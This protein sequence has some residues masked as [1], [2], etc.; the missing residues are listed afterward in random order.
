MLYKYIF[1]MDTAN[2]SQQ[3]H[4]RT[5]QVPLVNLQTSD[6][7]E[8]DVL[9]G[10]AA[11]VINNSGNRRFRA[12]TRYFR[13]IYATS[14]KPHDKNKISCAIVDAVRTANP[15]GR[16][17]KKHATKDIWYDIGD[18]KAREK[19]SQTIRDIY[20]KD[21]QKKQKIT[22][23]QRTASQN[24]DASASCSTDYVDD[25]SDS[26]KVVG[27]TVDPMN[28][29]NNDV[30]DNDTL[31][32]NADQV[33]K[34]KDVNKELMNYAC[35]EA[36][37]LAAEDKSK[38]VTSLSTKQQASAR[39]KATKLCDIPMQITVKHDEKSK[40]CC[41]I[42]HEEKA[43]RKKNE[44]EFSLA[45]QTTTKRCK[46]DNDADQ[47]ASSNNPDTMKTSKEQYQEGMEN[48]KQTGD[49]IWWTTGMDMSSKINDCTNQTSKYLSNEHSDITR[50]ACA[51]SIEGQLDHSK[52]GRKRV[53]ATGDQHTQ[54]KFSD[55]QVY[56]EDLP[57]K[58][59]YGTQTAMKRSIKE[60]D[61]VSSILEDRLAQQIRDQTKF[62]E[63]QTTMSQA[64][65]EIGKHD[66]SFSSE[67]L[68]LMQEISM[69]SQRPTPSTVRSLQAH[70]YGYP[71]YEQKNQ[72]S[73][74]AN[75]IDNISNENNISHL[76]VVHMAASNILSQSNLNHHD[77]DCPRKSA[78]DS[79]SDKS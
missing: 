17:L 52:E 4:K 71:F 47:Q 22:H 35:A 23:A 57:I 64:R 14:S 12:L 66:E 76:K 31:I 8:N 36:D 11:E 18:R 10:R 49:A 54:L 24:Q 3:Q 9:C 53:T 55:S 25:L 72:S 60:D 20:D 61:H 50:L 27:T 5:E 58:K 78:N 45:T 32:K 39:E 46:V 44:N 62:Q 37:D 40:T 15:P 79:T 70:L 42:E 38:L 51:S 77:S 26:S 33:V 7:N 2:E 41:S 48:E 73:C 63:L 74:M 68:S 16:F 59:T 43:K 56:K 69:W 67:C 65:N 13:S 75:L 6:I 34:K 29:T 19:T 21:K 28:H 1:N 30:E